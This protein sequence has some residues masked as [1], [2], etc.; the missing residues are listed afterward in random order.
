M[1]S[2]GFCDIFN[3]T[4]FK[5]QLWWLLLIVFE[6]HQYKTCPMRSDFLSSY[7]IFYLPVFNEVFLD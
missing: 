3:N 1:F 6:V 7:L 5:E 2:Y 4:F